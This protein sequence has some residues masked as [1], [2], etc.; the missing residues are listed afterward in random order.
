MDDDEGAGGDD[1]KLIVALTLAAAAAAASRLL[2][3]NWGD[4]CFHPLYLH[5]TTLDIRRV[6]FIGE[7]RLRQV[8]Q[9]CSDVTTH[10]SD[11]PVNKVGGIHRLEKVRQRIG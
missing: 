11:P 2:G 3:H 10:Q 8:F 7:T 4:T 6:G 9:S 1:E 5:N